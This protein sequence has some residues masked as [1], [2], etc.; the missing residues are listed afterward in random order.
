[1]F[2]VCYPDQ[3]GGSEV[4]I[5]N[6]QILSH[7]KHA[8][9]HSRISC[10]FQDL[11]DVLA[12]FFIVRSQS[13]I[14]IIVEMIAAD[15]FSVIITN[16]ASYFSWHISEVSYCIFYFFF[17]HDYYD[18][19]SLRSFFHCPS[20]SYP[21]W[22]ISLIRIILWR[23]CY[24][25]IFPRLIIFSNWT[26]YFCFWC[27]ENCLY[28]K[29]HMGSTFLPKLQGS[30]LAT[31]NF[32]FTTK[33]LITLLSFHICNAKHTAQKISPCRVFKLHGYGYKNS[34]FLQ[35]NFLRMHF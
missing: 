1:M 3:L 28:Q 32:F 12:K 24:F 5:C 16:L 2:W 9:C 23:C 17:W 13:K 30:F 19:L 35:I 33:V 10:N 29:C 20:G 15:H 25:L 4:V 11:L 22:F 27:A 26:P 8:A 21:K 6:N 14:V 34:S 7:A 18:L 31:E